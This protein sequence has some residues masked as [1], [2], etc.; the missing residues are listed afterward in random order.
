MTLRRALTLSICFSVFGC[1]PLLAQKAA[2][3]PGLLKK[4]E[5]GD[6]Q[7]QLTVG[8]AYL[9]GISVALD[10]AKAVSWLEKASNQGLPRAQF[11][12]G[13]L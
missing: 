2:L 11:D 1:L 3:D 8:E 12:L 13:A 10:N 6:A 7:A 9:S 5:A 4:A